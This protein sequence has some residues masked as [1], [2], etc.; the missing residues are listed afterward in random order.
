MAKETKT[1]LYSVIVLL[2]CAV[3]ILCL[4][5]I[6]MKNEAVETMSENQ[7]ADLRTITYK[8][9]KYYPKQGQKLIL[10][11][12]VDQ[13]GIFDSERRQENVQ[14]TSIMVI[15]IHEPEETFSVLQLNRN[16]QAEI[17]MSDQNISSR[18]ETAP[19][20]MATAYTYGKDIKDQCLNMSETV[21]HY[22]TGIEMDNY[23]VF[24]TDA[25]KIANDMV[26]GSRV[27]IRDDFSSTAP[28]LVQ[29][30]EMTL[31]GNQV[32]EYL[33]T[34]PQEDAVGREGALRRQKEVFECFTK[35]LNSKTQQDNGFPVDLF[36]SITEYMH[37]DCSD[38]R[39]ASI[40][41]SVS[42]YEFK[43]TIT[44]GGTKQEID[45]QEVYVVDEDRLMEICIRLFY[46]KK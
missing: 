20:P 26:G 7:D 37:T 43:E 3:F 12:G 13:P 15:A 32:L 44:L 17:L 23:V 41:A 38:D 22:L 27:L 36:Q 8:G 29:G 39:L 11:M 34:L 5:M 28:E 1:I 30:K 19:G 33:K 31:L 24:G 35:N 25:I 40:L 2:C 42:D 6:Q 21:S 10:Y 45:G 9:E 18:E 14:P 46:E 4:L 16:T